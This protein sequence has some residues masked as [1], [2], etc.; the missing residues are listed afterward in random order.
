MSQITHIEAQSNNCT[1]NAIS[2]TKII[3]KFKE[4]VKSETQ[5]L[6]VSA[7]VRK[8]NFYDIRA[9]SVSIGRFKARFYQ[10]TF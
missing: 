7:V 9:K 8:Y 3:I 2:W 5:A 4:F 10:I 6:A 1:F